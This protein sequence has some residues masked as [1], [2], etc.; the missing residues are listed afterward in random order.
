MD[1]NADEIYETFWKGIILGED[2]SVNM[3]QLKL[4]L[5]DFYTMINE[6]PKVYCEVTGGILSKPTWSAKTVLSY[7]EEKYKNKA[8]AVDFLPYDWDSITADCVTNADF[9]DALFEYLDIKQED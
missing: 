7:F 5:C 9:K 1:Y 3:D 6:V 8:I 2:G 4:E